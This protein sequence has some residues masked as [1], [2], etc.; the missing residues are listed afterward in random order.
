MYPKLHNAA[1]PGL[2]GKGGPGA[3][4]VIDLD[5]MLNITAK[6]KVDG[7]GFDGID[8]FAGEP[9]INTKDTA[10]IKELVQKLKDLSLNAGTL[11]APIWS[12]CAFG[13][14][15]EREEFLQQLSNACEFGQKLREAGVRPYGGIRID[16]AGSVERW[17]AAP[18]E[19]TNLILQTFDQASDIAQSYDEYLAAEGEICWGGMHSWKYMLQ[20]LQSINR[21]DVLGYQADLAHTSLFMLGANAPEHRIVSLDFDWNDKAVQNAAWKKIADALRPWTVDFHVAQNDGTVKGSG[22]HDKTGKHCLANDPNG[23]LDIVEVAGF[24]LTENGQPTRKLKHLCWD[25]C[26]FPNEVMLQPKTWETIL[27]V[28]LKIRNNCSWN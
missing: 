3:D 17:A 8:L 2:V 22:S 10:A 11:V 27:S 26:M 4:P 1:W 23:K 25:G 19:N 15:P 20:V 16:T 5:T 6:T 7:Q 18:E 28:M 21:P 12:G 9:H 24:W 14:Q 13:T